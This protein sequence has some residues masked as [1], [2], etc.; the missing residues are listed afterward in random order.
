M[1]VQSMN[2]LRVNNWKKFQHYKDRNPPWIKLHRDLLRDY[3]FICLQDASKM[4]LI[5][6]W[7][8]ASQMDGVTTSQSVSPTQTAEMT[9]PR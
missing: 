7:L 8:L 3:D 9:S 2:Y 1:E 6:I 5:L 4:Q